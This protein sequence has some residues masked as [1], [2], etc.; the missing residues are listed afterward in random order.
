MGVFTNTCTVQVS[1]NAM[2]CTAACAGTVEQVLDAVATVKLHRGGECCY[3]FRHAVFKPAPLFLQRKTTGHSRVV[4]KRNA[5]CESPSL[6]P[7]SPKYVAVI[8]FSFLS[9]NCKSISIKKT[10]RTV[11]YLDT[12]RH[13]R[14]FAFR[15]YGACSCTSLKYVPA[16][17]TPSHSLPDVQGILL[18]HPYFMKLMPYAHGIATAFTMRQASVLQ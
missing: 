2:I 6:V 16:V 8:R 5:A 12:M 3:E 9:C 15:T 17:P 14:R 1:I 7:P 11:T 10:I 4:A 13:R 18:S